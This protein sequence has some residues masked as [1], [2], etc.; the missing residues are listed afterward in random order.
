MQHQLEYCGVRDS[1]MALSVPQ[2]WDRKG[3]KSEKRNITALL[4]MSY[5]TRVSWHRNEAIFLLC[6]NTRQST[7]D[8][9]TAVHLSLCHDT[10]SET[11][12]GRQDKSQ[13]L[14][15]CH[16]IQPGGECGGGGQ[17]SLYV[18]SLLALYRCLQI[19]I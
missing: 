7:A 1:I 15:L 6:H 16:K 3:C 10:E 11:S 2:S 18:T 4:V 5:W 19:V 17:N 9:G 14:F 12:V 8:Q 13:Q